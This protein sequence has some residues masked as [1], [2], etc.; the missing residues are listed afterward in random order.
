MIT[1]LA[2]TKWPMIGNT[3]TSV[4][5]TG[6]NSTRIFTLVVVATF[7]WGTISIG[8]TASNTEVII[9]QEPIRAVTVFRALY[10]TIAVLACLPTIA[11][12]RGTASLDT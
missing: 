8:T 4:D 1:I 7:S 12:R 6:I 10:T 2:E 5:T 3:T 11:L 9:T